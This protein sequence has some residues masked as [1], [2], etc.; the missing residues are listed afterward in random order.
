MT[1]PEIAA[2][3]SI[4]RDS[5]YLMLERG[6]IPGVRLNRKWIITRYAFEQWEKTCGSVLWRAWTSQPRPEATFT[7]VVMP[8][9]NTNMIQGEWCGDTS[10]RWALPARIRN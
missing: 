9:S 2:R 1:I 10:S 4:G 5:V 7:E 8:V 3:L 6:T